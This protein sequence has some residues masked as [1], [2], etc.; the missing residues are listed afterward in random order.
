MSATDVLRDAIAG[1]REAA[2]DPALRSR[3]RLVRT[4]AERRQRAHDQWARDVAGC[5]DRE[6]VLE[7]AQRVAGRDQ[8]RR[9]W[10]RPDVAAVLE[11]LRQFGGYLPVTLES[12]ASAIYRDSTLT[13]D[14]DDL[15]LM[16]EHA[17]GLPPEITAAIARRSYTAKPGVLGPTGYENDE[18]IVAALNDPR[19]R[20]PRPVTFYRGEHHSGAHPQFAR[21]AAQARPGDLLTHHRRP[22]SA[23]IDPS[24]AASSEFALGGHLTDERGATP[25]GWLL[26]ITTDRAFYAGD[27]ARHGGGDDGLATF[28][29]EVVV[30]TPRL[31]VTGLREALVRSP[32]GALKRLLVLA[33][34]PDAGD[35]PR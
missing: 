24:I 9:A 26:A 12:V 14:P 23:S 2:D 17:A 11:D 1:A 4:R 25:G 22:I 27:R 31:R 6:L 7:A 15:T 10:H 29:K 13:L 19:S 32:H 18:E 21:T 35:S 5:Y 16:R 34:T 28:E 30:Y 33:C 20:L 8:P 3:W